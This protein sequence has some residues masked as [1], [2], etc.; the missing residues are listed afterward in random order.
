MV[1]SAIFNNLAN[2]IDNLE[3]MEKRL[4]ALESASADATPPVPENL[5]KEISHAH[6]DVTDA[7]AALQKVWD[8]YIVPNSTP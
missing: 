1:P 6:K 4:A 3:T 2:S 8:E 7:K 5:Q